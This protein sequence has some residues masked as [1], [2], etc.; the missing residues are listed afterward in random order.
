MAV[1]DYDDFEHTGPGTLA[2]RYMRSFWQPVF[3][4]EDLTAGKAIPVR[5]MSEDF[6]LYRGETGDSHVVA[7]RCA[8]RGTQL[9]VGWVEGDCIRCRYHGWMYDGTGQCVEQPGEDPAF[10][11]KVRI[12]TY[13]TE[14]YLGLIFAYLGDGEAPPLRRFPNHDRPGILEI[15]APEI[16]PA[17]YFNRLEND[18]SHVPW[19]H[20]ESLVRGGSRQAG[21]APTSV[22]AHETDFG[23]VVDVVHPTGRLQRNY[24]YL[25]NADQ[26]NSG[27]SESVSDEVPRERLSWTVPIDDETRVSFRV[28]LVPLEGDAAAAYEQRV[29]QA[30][31]A[32]GTAAWRDEIA[33]QVVAG[34]RSIED[35]EQ[36]INQYNLFRIEDYAT[37]VGQGRIAD[38][39]NDHLGRIDAGTALRRQIWRRELQA[40]AEGRPLTSW[41]MPD[42][43]ATPEQVAVP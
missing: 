33:R 42:R 36:G 11:S 22:S 40:L 7:F 30:H 27:S 12:R 34:T 29:R 3:R 26:H 43:A 9:N 2:G 32:E 20:H 8:H 1:H 10:A 4:A 5:I 23:F 6:T 17:N 25:P 37:Q 31:P 13:P 21:A 41:R 35:V 15:A 28:D 14:E 19:T 16:M 18:P 24:Y 38:R 39:S